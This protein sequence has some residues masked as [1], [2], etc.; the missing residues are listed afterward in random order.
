MTRLHAGAV[1]DRAP[2]PKYRGA[3]DFAEL[4]SSAPLPRPGTLRR[5]REEVGAGLT[6][7]L[8]VPASATRSKL[9]P[10]RPDAAMEAALRWTLEAAA[11]LAPRFLVVPTSADFTTGQRDRDLFAR[12]VERLEPTL[13]EALVWHP[14]GLWE[15]EVAQPFAERLAATLA[16][17]PLDA[18]T[19]PPGPVTYARLR[20]IGGRS[21]FTE[22]ALREVLDMLEGAAEAWVS[23]ESPRSFTE[24]SRL[25]ALARG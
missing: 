13:R 4:K 21:R 15:P 10:F 1:V 7:G 18:E 2:G 19:V 17:D 3:L 14:A 23:I 11:A 8:V 25:A 20:A 24:A 12:W 16:F 22:T 9:G 6:L 5:W